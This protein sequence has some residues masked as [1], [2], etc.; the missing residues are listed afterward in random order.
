MGPRTLL[1]QIHLN[2]LVG[3]E[4]RPYG[5]PAKGELMEGRRTRSDHNAVQI[6]F[7][8]VVDDFLLRGIRTSKH[9]RLGHFDVGFTGNFLPDF[10]AIHIVGDVAAAIA[11]V[12]AQ[13]SVVHVRTLSTWAPARAAAADEWRMV[14]GMSITAAV[15]PAAKTPSMLVRA[16]L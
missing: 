1:T 7:L 2:V 16:G 13:T 9:G 5:D 15:D 8:N 6:Q 10:F 12:H 4:S 3:I 14:S 11:D